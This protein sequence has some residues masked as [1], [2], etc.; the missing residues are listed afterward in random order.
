MLKL[1]LQYFAHLMQLIG[2]DPDARKDWRQGEKGETEDEMIGWH[3]WLNGHKFEQT[4]G[5]GG[6]GSLAWYS[7]WGRKESDMTERL[8]NKNVVRACCCFYVDR[9]SIDPV[10]FFERQISLVELTLYPC[11]K[12]VDHEVWVW[13]LYYIP[14]I[15]IFIFFIEITQSWLMQGYSKFGK[16]HVVLLPVFKQW[17][18]LCVYCHLNFGLSL[19]IS[20]RKNLVQFWYALCWIS[21]VIWGNWHL[22]NSEFYN[23]WVY[24]SI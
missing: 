24:L 18:W 2:K 16:I 17:F 12:L 3:H 23:H 4:P 9:Y 1:E 11:Q 14:L 20:M 21:I 10:V 8:N 19:S 22:H 6:W 15:Y 7:P 5:D 13:I